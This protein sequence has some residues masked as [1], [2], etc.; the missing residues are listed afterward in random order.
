VNQ[1]HKDNKVSKECVVQQ[2]TQGS[3]GHQD[4]L[5]HK[6]KLAHRDQ[7]DHKVQLDYK[8]NPSRIIDCLTID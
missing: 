1:D 6:V 3:M 5:D 8:Y 7:P 4:Q 2:V